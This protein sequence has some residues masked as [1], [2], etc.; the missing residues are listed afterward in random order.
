MASREAEA[1]HNRSVIVEAHRDV[2]EMVRLK[3]SGEKF[4]LLN[5][6][7]PRLKKGG[8]TISIFAVCGDSVTHSKGTYRYLHAALE[9]IDWLRQEAEA[10]AGKIKIILSA[11]DVPSEPSRD[12][13]YFLLSFE[14]GKPLEGR[15]EHLRNFY[16]LGLRAMQITWNLRNELADGIR[17][18]ETKGGLTR[19]GV[20]VVREMNRLGMLIDLAH[21]SRTGFFH[22]LDIA[23]G[24]VVCSHSNCRK[25][26]LHPRTID[27]DQ[28]KALAGT[29]GVMGINA[30]ATQVAAK[31][32]TLDKLLDHIS[33]IAEIVGVDHV[34]LGLDF[35]KDDGPLHPEDELFNTG[36][37]KLLPELENE[38]DL[39]NL[40]DRLVKRGFKADE[41]TK[42]L[43]GNFLRVLKEVL[44]SRGQ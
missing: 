10:S 43:G 6:T 35:V 36:E 33:Y 18:E 1:I 11:D 31:E 20:S 19:F 7:L 29:G 38:E 14:G 8:V 27:D 34:G 23:T 13:V 41:I 22:V 24:P 30:I 28:I 12:A 39:L 3:N 15:L 4:P 37:N 16:W 32:P 25:L 40:T 42:I 21:I 2:F 9:N 5:A 17:E 26:N 44:K